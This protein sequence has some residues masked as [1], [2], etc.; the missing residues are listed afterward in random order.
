MNNM[1]ERLISSFPEDER[2]AVIEH[3]CDTRD[4]APW[5]NENQIWASIVISS[6]AS[7][8]EF[9]Q[10]LLDAKIEWRDVV[11]AAGLAVD[12][13]ER[14]AMEWM[15]LRLSDESKNSMGSGGDGSAAKG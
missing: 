4:F 12:D 6:G 7:L 9:S 1:I 14:V 10:I 11:I 13:W 2:R 5:K 3:I 8:D 15:A